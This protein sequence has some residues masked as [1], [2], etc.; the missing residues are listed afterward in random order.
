MAISSEI[1]NPIGTFFDE[2]L[3]GHLRDHFFRESTTKLFVWK[4]FFDAAFSNVSSAAVRLPVGLVISA[5]CLQV[6]SAEIDSGGGMVSLG[7]E[8]NHSSIG[9]QMETG[10]SFS[11]LIDVLYPDNPAWN[12]GIDSDQN[13]LPDSWEILNFGTIGQNTSSDGDGDGNSNLL[14]FLAGTNPNAAASVFRPSSRLE[15][16][17]LILTVPTVSGRNYRVWGTPN[18]QAGWGNAPLDSISGDGSIIEWDYLMSLSPT[19]R[20]FLRIE[21]MIPPPN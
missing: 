9:A 18:L 5:I 2:P 20:F 8:L 3:S 1:T 4:N 14:E 16:G 11:G 10:R 17:R 13:G 19:G 12:P 21:I 6:L 7:N 15:T